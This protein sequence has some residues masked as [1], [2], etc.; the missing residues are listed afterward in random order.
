MS[1]TI[2]YQSYTIT[3]SPV[4]NVSQWGLRISI[5]WKS[6]GNTISKSFWMPITYPTEEEADIHG[7]SSGQHIIDEGFL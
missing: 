7:I 6:D 5:S 1:R 3:S 2:L 4:Q